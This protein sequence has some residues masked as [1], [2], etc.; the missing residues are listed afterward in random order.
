MS[1]TGIEAI[2]AVV[3]IMPIINEKAVIDSS[4]IP[5]KRYK[6][7]LEAKYNSQNKWIVE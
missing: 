6:I 1:K 7:V 3:D 4:K 2:P 5:S